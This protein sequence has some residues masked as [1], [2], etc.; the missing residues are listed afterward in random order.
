MTVANA[1]TRNVLFLCKRLHVAGLNKGR[2]FYLLPD[3]RPRYST[4]ERNRHPS[5][6]GP[7]LISKSSDV[8]PS[9]SR[10]FILYPGYLSLEEQCTLLLASLHKLDTTLTPSREVRTRRKKRS[11][12]EGTALNPLPSSLFLSDELYDFWEVRRVPVYELH[13]QLIWSVILCSVSFIRTIMTV[14]YTI[15]G[16][17]TYP[18]GLQIIIPSRFLVLLIHHQSTPSF[19]SQM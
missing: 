11:Q 15:I 17:F 1:Y 2:C 7:L 19:P 18:R 3:F 6:S 9:L 4:C 14:S 13:D 5:S 10:H 16:K 8:P 12:P